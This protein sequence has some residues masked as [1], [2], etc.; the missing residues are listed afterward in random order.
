MM[1]AI[2]FYDY[3]LTFLDEFRLV[4]KRK[5]S[6][7]TIIFVLNRYLLLLNMLLLAYTFLR[8]QTDRVSPTLIDVDL[9][10]KLISN[11][12]PNLEV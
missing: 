7:V 2:T 12:T 6:I 9:V 5:Y 11:D 10:S 3:A 8:M 4:W 1:K